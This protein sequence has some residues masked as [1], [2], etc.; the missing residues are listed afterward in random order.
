MRRDPNLQFR[1]AQAFAVGATFFF[2]A[3]LP[4]I[5]SYDGMDYVHLAKVLGTSAFPADWNFLRT[6]L[7]PLSLKWILWLGGEQPQAAMF[8]TTLLGLGGL[9]LVGATVRRIAGPSVAAFAI[10][11]ITFYPVLIGYEH[12]LLSETGIFFWLALLVWSLIATR[13]VGHESILIPCCIVL[14]MAG[15]YYWRPTIP[16][17][18]PLAAIAFLLLHRLSAE[19]PR[20][21]HRLAQD[22]KQRWRLALAQALIIALGPWLLAY[23][24]AHFVGKYLVGAVGEGTIA[25]GMFKEVLVPPDDPVLRD[26]RDEYKVA[27]QQDSKRGRLP[28]DGVSIAGRHDLMDKVVTDVHRAGWMRLIARYPGRYIV[29]ATKSTLLFLGVPDHTHL[30]DENW[31]FPRYVFSLWPGE[32]SF[33][34]TVGWNRT[35]VHFVPPPY[36][37]SMAG[38]MLL[39]LM[40]GSSWVV[41]AGSLASLAWLVFSIWRADAVGITVTAIPLAFLLLHALTLMAADRYGFPVYPMMLANLVMVI[42]LAVRKRGKRDATLRLQRKPSLA[43]F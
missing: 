27:I 16:Y 6:P 4:L 9:L 5:V 24:W 39:K 29:A 41:L 33:E 26:V 17:L 18:S 12:M 25:A 19:T 15:G 42:G 21:Y 23:P 3:C 8:D 38:K 14:I 30:E 35:L 37:G 34:N 28:L 36:Q 22:L 40:R 7:F 2:F 43:S 13:S 31:F 20:P 32:D 11:V 10:L 1:L